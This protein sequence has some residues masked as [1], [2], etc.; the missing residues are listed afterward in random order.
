MVS[1]SEDKN[2]RLEILKQ[3]EL[4]ISNLND[5]SALEDRLKKIK[6]NHNQTYS[7]IDEI[8]E[9]PLK[10]IALPEADSTI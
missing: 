9:E 6:E 10:K 3:E 1:K 8:Q 2:K 5:S 7:V 4:I